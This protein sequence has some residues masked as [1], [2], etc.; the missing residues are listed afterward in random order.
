MKGYQASIT[1][2]HWAQTSW[3]YFGVYQ[4]EPGCSEGFQEAASMANVS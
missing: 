1:V 2:A 4:D 3:A